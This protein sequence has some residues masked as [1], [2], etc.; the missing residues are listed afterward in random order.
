MSGPIHGI[1]SR[2]LRRV[3]RIKPELGPE[4]AEIIPASRRSPVPLNTVM[5][6]WPSGT[7]KAQN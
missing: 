1:A 2:P 6:V 4:F 3:F 5:T 7:A